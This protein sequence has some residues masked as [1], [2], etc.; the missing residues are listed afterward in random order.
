M[1]SVK[2][3]KEANFLGSG[4]S[5]PPSFTHANHQLDMNAKD[6]NIKQSIDIIL[7]TPIGARCTNPKFGCGLNRF[8]FRNFD[9]TLEGEII[10][11]IKTAL[12]N[13]EPRI[14][15]ENV[16]VNLDD[17]HA[18]ILLISINYIINMTNSRHNHVFPFYLNEASNLQ[19]NKG[20]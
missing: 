3:A 12:L 2:Q 17:S 8:L 16:L 13:F 19:Q 10:N 5:F 1:T 15:I 9:S 14:K 18:L 11:E 6:I 7:Q 4:W 20:E